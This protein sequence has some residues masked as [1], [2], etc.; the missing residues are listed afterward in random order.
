MQEPKSAELTSPAAGPCT[1][2]TSDCMTRP[3]SLPG[4]QD[5]YSIADQ[6]LG[7]ALGIE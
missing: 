4:S 1:S 6:T 5:P 2:L 3:V 7:F